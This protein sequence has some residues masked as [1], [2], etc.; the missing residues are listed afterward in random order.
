MAIVNISGGGGGLSG[1]GGTS[2]TRVASGSGTT[3]TTTTPPP[4]SPQNPDPSVA[5]TPPIQINPNAPG[6]FTGGPGPDLGLK[7]MIVE[8][9]K[10]SPYGYKPGDEDYWV[11]QIKAG[12]GWSPY[13]QDKIAA[14]P[15]AGGSGGAGDSGGGV[16]SDP[17][18]KEWE[19]LLRTLVGRLKTPQQNPD[20]A[21]MIDYLRQYFQQ[22]QGPAYTPAQMELQQTQTLDPLERQRTAAQQQLIEHASARGLTPESGIIQKQ[23][24]DL[25]RSFDQ[26]RT[27]TQAGFANQAIQQDQQNHLQAANVAQTISSLQ[28]QNNSTDEQR[29]M[30]AVNSLFQIPQLADTRLGLANQTLNAGSMNPSNI[31]N[32]LLGAQQTAQNQTNYDANFWAQLFQNVLPL[33]H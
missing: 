23:L 29:L 18:T 26:S 19:D 5:N 8:G 30:Q 31:I 21:P 24:E 22:L 11:T 15:Q 9:L 7:Q 10:K 1:W 16:F 33:L 14:G 28:N 2:S 32:Q 6:G 27:T 13:W 25:N 20:F 3:T 17:A 4:L 12:G